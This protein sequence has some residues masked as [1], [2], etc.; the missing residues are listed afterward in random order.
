MKNFSEEEFIQRFKQKLLSYTTVSDKDLELLTHLMHRKHFYKGEVILKEGEVCKEYYFVLQGYLRTYSIKNEREVNVNFYFED[1]TAC[2]FASFRN[3]TPSQFY[4]IA[5][6]DCIVYYGTK[7]ETEP[8]LLTEVSLHALLFR[9]FQDLYLK[10][11]EHSDNFKLFTPEERYKYM[12]AN[13]LQYLQRIPVKY[14]ASYLGVSRE[15]LSRIRKKIN[16]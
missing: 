16:L 11:E 15:T 9:F 7:K 3:N 6:E 4:M 5:M 12:L 14:L 10:E 13:Q 2:N 1:H 8:V